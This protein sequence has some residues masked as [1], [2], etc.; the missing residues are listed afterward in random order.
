MVAIYTAVKNETKDGIA[1][2]L[3][4]FISL[5]LFTIILLSIDNLLIK[6]LEFKEYV[7]SLTTGFIIV[8]ILSIIILIINSIVNAFKKSN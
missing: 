3:S 1:F 6:G 8:I 5:V 7:F 4:I 2:Y